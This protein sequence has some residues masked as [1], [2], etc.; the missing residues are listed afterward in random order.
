MKE[1][2]VRNEGLG[3]FLNTVLVNEIAKLW[4]FQKIL[5]K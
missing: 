4:P 5:R 2:S 1:Q 3:V